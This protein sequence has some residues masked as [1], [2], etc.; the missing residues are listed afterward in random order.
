MGSP[1]IRMPHGLPR[2]RTSCALLT[3]FTVLIAWPSPRPEVSVLVHPAFFALLTW[4]FWRTARASTAL[5]SQPM[6]LV[7]GGFFVLW[8][9]FTLAAAIHFSGLERDYSAA[10]YLRQTCERGAWFVLGTTLLA[11]GLMLW[12]PEI[13]RSH[14]LLAAHAEDQKGQLKKAASERSE[15][16]QRLVEADRL[17]MLGE[18][19]ASIAHDLRNPLTIVKG[20]AESL[21]RRPRDARE[22]AEHTDVIRRNIERADRT[23]ESLIDLARPKA[24]QLQR[25]AIDAVLHETAELLQVEARRRRV[26]LQVLESRCTEVDADHTLLAQALMNLTLN[27][28]HASAQDRTI[29]L[30]ARSF[31]EWLAIYIEDRGIGLSDEVRQ[32]L[33]QPFFTTKRSGTGLG[34]PSCRRIAN[35]LGGELRLYPRSGGGARALLWLPRAGQ[36]GR[37]STDAPAPSGGHSQPQPQEAACPA[38]S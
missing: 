34:L 19:A 7:T 38:G 29:R 4:F 35:E 33:F 24:G 26:T 32:K 28:L 12:I 8:L 17:G 9:G 2:P 27:A 20:T 18:L 5:Q 14:E 3:L 22:I 21:C 23:I 30:G 1:S 36:A 13:V 31:G 11:Y 15:L 16:E 37:Q 6:R 10:A 25:L